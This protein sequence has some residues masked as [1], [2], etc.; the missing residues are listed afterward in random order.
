MKSSSGERRSAMKPPPPIATICP[1]TR[2]VSIRASSEFRVSGSLT[3]FVPQRCLALGCLVRV[4][5]AYLPGGRTW[6]ACHKRGP[7]FGERPSVPF[8]ASGLTIARRDANFDARP[9]LR[10]LARLGEALLGSRDRSRVMRVVCSYTP[11][12]STSMLRTSGLS[13]F[14]SVCLPHRSRIQR[15]NMSNVSAHHAPFVSVTR[16]RSPHERPAAGPEDAC[17]SCDALRGCRGISRLGSKRREP[18]SLVAWRRRA[19]FCS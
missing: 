2:L 5:G 18:G 8:S 3:S 1:G 9:Q 19:R 4:E 15:L 14:F 7:R 10:A 6:L 16:A 17:S 11:S 13:A 12:K